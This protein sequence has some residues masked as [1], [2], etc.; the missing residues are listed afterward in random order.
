MVVFCNIGD[1]V[2]V[3][4]TSGDIVL[5]QNLETAFAGFLIG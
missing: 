3:Q 4:R 5:A 1:V 2:T